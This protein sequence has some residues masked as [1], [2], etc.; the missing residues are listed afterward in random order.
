MGGILAGGAVFV[1]AGNAA[2]VA[3]IAALV[4]VSVMAICHLAIDD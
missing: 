4:A 3:G 1:V 2:L